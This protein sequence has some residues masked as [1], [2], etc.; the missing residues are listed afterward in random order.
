M[1]YGNECLAIEL[2][3]I[4]ILQFKFKYST[5][6]DYINYFTTRFPWFPQIVPSLIDTLNYTNALLEGCE[7][8]A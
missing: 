5:P 8:T 2:K 3:V 7:N 6:Y 1:F 4:S